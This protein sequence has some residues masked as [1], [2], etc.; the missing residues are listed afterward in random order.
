MNGAS[1]L[2]GMCPLISTIGSRR[3]I[4][5]R[6]RSGSAVMSA[7]SPETKT[8][9]ATPR[10]SSSSVNSSSLTPPG[11]SVHSSGV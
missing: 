11:V 3:S 9:P 10:S 5:R 1:H 2:V 4:S 8:M 6:Y 7:C